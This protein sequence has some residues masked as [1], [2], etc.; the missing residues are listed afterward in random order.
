MGKVPFGA[1]RNGATITEMILGQLPE[2]NGRN[3]L[4]VVPQ[5]MQLVLN[6]REVGYHFSYGLVVNKNSRV[7]RMS[8]MKP[9]G[10]SFG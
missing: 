1:T 8:S 10:T 7:L 2:V 4:G 6:I 9:K 3:I 5:I